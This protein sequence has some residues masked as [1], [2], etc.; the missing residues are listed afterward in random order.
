MPIYKLSFRFVYR[1]QGKM[2]RSISL[3]G[4]L[5]PMVQAHAGSLITMVGAQLHFYMPILKEQVCPVRGN[6]S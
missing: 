3:H 6:V 1:G 4:S 5:Q 2:G